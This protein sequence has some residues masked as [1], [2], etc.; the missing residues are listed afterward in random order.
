MNMGAILV[1]LPALCWWILIS[2][3]LQA[4][5][6]NLADNDPAVTEKSKFSFHM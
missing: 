1:M 3:Y 5:I 4:L 6:Q 2:V